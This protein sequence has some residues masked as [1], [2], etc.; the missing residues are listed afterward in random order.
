VSPATFTHD[1]PGAPADAW[2]DPHGPLLDLAGVRR[3][4][5][6]GAHP[7]DETLGAGGLLAT[8]V[9]AGID[10]QVVL[11]TS[12]E[13]SHPA[14]PTV[15]P[16]ELARRRSAE[17]VAA[18]EELG[19]DP[20]QVLELGLPDGALVEHADELTRVLVE[21]V[22]DGRDTL[23]AAPW[24]TDGHPDH[25]AAG[26]AAATAARRTGATLAEYPVWFWHWGDPADLRVDDM[27]RLP[28]PPAIAE[29]KDRAVAAH[30]TQ[31]EPLSDH[32]EDRVLLGPE[33]LAHFRRGVERFWVT[34]P[35][36]CPDHTFERL[37]RDQADPWGV[38]SR[39]FEERK[40]ALVLAMLPRRSFESVLD[41][42]CSTGA[43]TAALAA[44][45]SERGTLL[46]VDGAD[47]ALARARQRVCAMPAVTV[48]KLEVPHEWPEGDFDLVVVSEVGYFLSPTDV[49]R[50]AHR[51]A[52]A[53]QPGG[54]VVLC[55]WVHPIS[56]WVLDAGGVHR[57]FK[58][59]GLPPLAAT[60]DDSDVTI[61]VYAADWPE[62][63]A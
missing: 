55:H 60:Y 36:D 46:A 39:W 37:H 28:L 63:D 49:E 29:A 5:V 31:V 22:G 38:D 15:T 58:A 41:V 23:L 35:Q 4:V 9:A 47:E 53:L 26:T 40:R 50:L 61:R 3:V 19:L 8:A 52:D 44:R 13:G 54:V 62:A 57:H 34:A 20:D 33:F 16:A 17:A 48:R 11:A 18:A 6:V 43:L 12:G 24:R 21:V 27:R 56:G 51:I 30:R 2:P 59:E 45:L 32:P 7:D 10:V 42:G 14:S 25:E 1:G